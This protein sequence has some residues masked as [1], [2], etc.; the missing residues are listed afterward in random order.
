MKASFQFF[1]LIISFWAQGQTSFEEHVILPLQKN[2]TPQEKVFIHTNKTSYFTD[3]ILWFKAYVGNATNA[4]STKT[5]KLYV[6]LLN[7]ESKIIAS[8]N[9]FVFKGV[10]IGQF[11]LGSIVNPGTYFI[12]AYS[13][14]LRNFDKEFVYLQEIMVLGKTAKIEQVEKPLYDIQVFPEGGYLLAD[15]ENIIGIKSMINGNGINFSG[16]IVNSKN[17]NVSSFTN[18]HLGMTKCRLFYKKGERYTALV[19]INDTLIRIKIPIAKNKGILLSVDNSKKDSLI[20]TIKTNKIAQNKF[21]DAQYILLYHQ[22]NKIVGLIEINTLESP[23][24]TIKSSKNKFYQGVNTVTLFKNNQPIAERKIFIERENQQIKTSIKK[25]DTETDSIVYKLKL[26]NKNQS[27]KADLSISIFP[28]KT[29]NFNEKQNLKS[30]FLLTPHVKG[31]VESPAYYFNLENKKRKEHLDLLLLTQ[32]WSQYSLEQMIH[33]LNPKSEFDFELGHKLSGVI[34]GPLLYN[35]LA[36]ISNKN[37]L[38]VKLFLNGKKRF[39]FDRLLIHK[40]D[41]LKISYMAD[42]GEVFKIKNLKIDS[43]KTVN[44]PIPIL[45]PTAFNPSKKNTTKSTGYDWNPS[46]VIALDE[47]LLTKKKRSEAYLKRRMLIKKYKPLVFDIGKYY[48]IP[49]LEN[50][51]DFNDDL[52]SFLNFNEGVTLANFEGIEYYLKLPFEKEALLYID[53]ERVESLEF[54]SLNLEMENVKNIMLQPIKGNRIY[55]VF[56]TEN[57]KKNIVELFNKH[58]VLDGY[59]LE[60]QYYKPLYVFDDKRIYDWVETDWKPKIITNKNGEAFFRISKDRSTNE[61]IFSI[62]GFTNT[63]LLISE[64]LRN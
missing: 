56:T 11:N 55:Q 18:Q 21:D 6:N 57:Y 58:I 59:D 33:S 34:I 30:A 7:S 8:K 37:K 52:L 49:L 26:E 28:A 50:Y 36:L 1:F 4:P 32:G 15:M 3:D 39:Q 17:E 54:P 38:I 53:G 16:K 12:Q 43:A 5:T 24:T 35:R 19:N 10:G 42:S 14:N 2:R 44:V 40:G 46:G 47:V 25:V 63:G 64:L 61:Y 20:L 9:I 23:E 45:P 27:T 29:K 60:K 41:T 31:H 51:K 22:R 62:Q 48:E 13:N